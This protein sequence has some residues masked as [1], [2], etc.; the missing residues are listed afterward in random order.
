[1]LSDAR[2]LVEADN[3]DLA[4]WYYINLYPDNKKEVLEDLQKLNIDND[5]LSKNIGKSFSLYAPLD[6]TVTKFENGTMSLNKE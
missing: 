6:P 3:L 4:I 5:K 2:A 1:M